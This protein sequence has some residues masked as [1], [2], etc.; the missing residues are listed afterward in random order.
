MNSN[1]DRK[2]IQSFFEKGAWD[3]E[4]HKT[5][6]YHNDATGTFTCDI[7]NLNQL[8]SSA[9]KEVTHCNGAIEWCDRLYDSDWNELY[10]VV[11]DNPMPIWNHQ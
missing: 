6:A 8:H 9:M 5:F 2:Q 1:S 10:G 3:Y 4:T 7:P 11:L